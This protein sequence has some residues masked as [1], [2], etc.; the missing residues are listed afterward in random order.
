MKSH[1]NISIDSEV[2]QRLLLVPNLNISGLINNFLITFVNNPLNS[3]ELGIK[4]LE[5]KLKNSEFET[6]IIKNKIK[7]E[8]DKMKILKESEQQKINETDIKDKSDKR[9]IYENYMGLEPYDKVKYLKA[10][11]LT[12]REIEEYKDL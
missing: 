7:Q 3:D 4:E 10:I 8:A 5:E 6:L 9:K 1:I 12:I 2:Y 11:G